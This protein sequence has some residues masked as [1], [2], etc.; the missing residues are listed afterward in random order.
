MVAS[1]HKCSFKQFFWRL[2]VLRTD[3]QNCEVLK[4]EF[5]VC[6]CMLSA[7]FESRHCEKTVNEMRQ[8]KFN[9]VHCD[10]PSS[11]SVYGKSGHNGERLFLGF[12][13]KHK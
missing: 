2:V 10:L 8:V 7:S 12:W 3:K 4:K 13:A 9:N 11:L 5:L 6:V 1:T